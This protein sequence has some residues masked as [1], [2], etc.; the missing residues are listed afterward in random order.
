MPLFA[1]LALAF[2]SAI[3]Q[4]STGSPADLVRRAVQN[5]VSQ[6][7]DSN[8]HF[9]F[10]D[11]RNTTHTSQTKLIV[12]TREAAAGMIIEQDGQP[13]TPQQQEAEDARLQNYIRNPEEIARKR[14]QEKEDA[15]RTMKIVRALPAAFLY[16]PD[17]TETGTASV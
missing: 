5:E 2:Y 11:Q 3:A 12:E 10:R 13:L 6:N 9:M 1:F 16:E 8:A 7:T 17:G 4:P 15:E 14:R